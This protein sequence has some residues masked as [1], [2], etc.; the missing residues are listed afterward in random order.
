MFM[1]THDAA[2]MAL[3]LN[4]AR[5]G[6]GLTSPNP[7][8]GAVVVRNEKII[9]T[10]F[11]TEDGA[12]HAEVEALKKLSPGDASGATMYVNLEPCC[13]YGRT[14]PCT[15]A[16]I[17]AG[18]S[19]VVVANT[20]PDERVAGQGIALLRSRGI[21]VEVGVLREE[22]ERLN[23]IYF[24][25][26]RKG[27]PYIVLK[28]ALTLDGKVATRTGD[29]KW[30]SGPE[31]RCYS[32]DLRRRLK[33]ILIGKNTLFEDNPRLNCRFPGFEHKP[34]DKIVLTSSPQ[35]VREHFAFKALSESPGRSFA[36]NAESREIFLEFCVSQKI[37]SVLVEGGGK[38][39]QWFLKNSLADRV[40]LF[41]RPCFMGSDGR[42]VVTG[43][44]P[45]KLSE[46]SDF[47][48]VGTQVLGN[49]V[50]IDLAKGEPLCLR[51]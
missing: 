20:D 3:V 16:I 29:A 27:L 50:M 42:P 24:H 45:E 12:P 23:S 43:E 28:A 25:N 14:P 44:G 17:A 5:K 4:L 21:A 41:Y 10:G 34:L 6:L 39:L 9:A 8:V 11:H 36:L 1:N 15:D 51:D 35:Q 7:M 19:R 33:A 2:F 18:I 46:L 30:I 37:D 49:N 48:V 47:S 40:I 38:V 26:R 13:H 32:Q 22:G 31:S